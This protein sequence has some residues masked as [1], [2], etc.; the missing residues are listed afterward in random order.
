VEPAQKEKAAKK[1]PI[2]DAHSGVQSSDER[3]EGAQ[4]PPLPPAPPNLAH[5]LPMRTLFVIN[6]KKGDISNKLTMGTFLISVDKRHKT[7]LTL[8]PPAVKLG[9]IFLQP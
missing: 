2:R 8:T 1:E 6:G 5:T 7:A 9:S 3:G 4:S